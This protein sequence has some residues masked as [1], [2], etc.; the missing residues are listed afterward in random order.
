MYVVRSAYE[1]GRRFVSR[2]EQGEDGEVVSMPFDHAINSLSSTAALLTQ[3]GPE[4]W[5]NAVTVQR[6]EVQRTAIYSTNNFTN[7]DCDPNPFEEIGS[8]WKKIHLDDLGPFFVQLWKSMSDDRLVARTGF[9]PMFPV[10]YQRICMITPETT[11]D[12]VARELRIISKEMYNRKL[13][14]YDAINR[15]RKLEDDPLP[16]GKGKTQA[17]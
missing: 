12:V 8:M 1:P 10:C 6:T 3:L 16:L 9:A 5:T 15:K 2:V 17:L 7:V 13:D 11:K 4:R 14:K